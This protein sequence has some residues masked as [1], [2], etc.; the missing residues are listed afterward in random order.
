M[1]DT[2]TLDTNYIQA[3]NLTVTDMSTLIGI[4]NAGGFTQSVNL[5]SRLGNIDIAATDNA[6][7]AKNIKLTA[8]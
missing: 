5:R 3:N 7:T 1:L 6:L 8:R 2:L 4:L